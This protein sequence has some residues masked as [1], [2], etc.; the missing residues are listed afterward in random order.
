MATKGICGSSSPRRR[1]SFTGL[2]RGATAIPAA[3]P[4]GVMACLFG[5]GVGV[6][7]LI[8]PALAAECRR[9]TAPMLRCRT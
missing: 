2:T 1:R 5:R 7:A 8:H 6:D 9:L 4:E 3:G